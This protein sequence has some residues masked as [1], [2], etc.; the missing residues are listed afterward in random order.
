MPL[1]SDASRTGGRLTGEDMC[2]YMQ[3]FSDKYLK[4][5]IRF[6]TE[7]LDIRRDDLSDTWFVQVEDKTNG[8][9]EKLQFSRIVLCSGVSLCFKYIH[10]H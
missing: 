7:V 6:Q 5:K 9:Q 1:P 8:R 2:G 10:C 4:D 3:A